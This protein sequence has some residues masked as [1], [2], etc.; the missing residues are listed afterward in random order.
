MRQ[1]CNDVN[2]IIK[3]TDKTQTEY[4]E[5][6]KPLKVLS[7][8]HSKCLQMNSKSSEGMRENVT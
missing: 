3:M 7:E 6:I 8:V 5:E 4:V 1:L 2:L